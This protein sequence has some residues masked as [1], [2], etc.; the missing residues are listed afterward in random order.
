MLRTN[1]YT[2]AYIALAVSIR[3]VICA[4]IIEIQQ[5]QRKIVK[6]DL[7]KDIPKKLDDFWLYLRSTLTRYVI[8]TEISLLFSLPYITYPRLVKSVKIVRNPVPSQGQEGAHMYVPSLVI[9]GT[10][11]PV[12]KVLKSDVTARICFSQQT[13]G[14]LHKFNKFQYD[15]LQTYMT[16]KVRTQCDIHLYSSQARVFFQGGGCLCQK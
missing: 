3:N 2:E 4:P 9:L 7:Q 8:R 1:L 5:S 13:A 10:A 16:I 6:E 12:T 14:I 15:H 11:H